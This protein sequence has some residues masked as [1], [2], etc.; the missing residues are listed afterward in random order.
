MPKANFKKKAMDYLYR[1][2][3]EKKSEH[4]I[5][6]GFAIGTFISALP[7]PGF[8]ILLGVLIALIFKKVNKVSLFASFI[9]WNPITI[10]PVYLLSYKIGNA[11][12]VSQPIIRYNIVMIDLI[13][14]ISR[15]FLLGN[16]IL[17]VV[18]GIFFYVLIRVIIKFNKRLLTNH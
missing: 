13:Y 15:R 8:N 14:N 12:F 11:M 5:A 2:L 3:S 4:S 16:L 1:M 10:I 18:L 17:A 6:L 9:F 7:T